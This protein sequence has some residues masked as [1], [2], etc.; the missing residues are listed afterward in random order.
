[1]TGGILNINKPTGMTS[2][3]V[4]SLVRKLT[5]VRRVGHAGTLD[6]I[7]QGVLPICLGQA[8]RVVEYLIGQPKVYYATI[9]LGSATDTYDSEGTV[10]A[11]G[12][13]SDISEAEVRS[14]LESF[15]GEIDQ[16]PPMYSAVKHEGQPLYRY[17]RAG[18]EAPR[19][20]RKAMIY[21]IELRRFAPPLIKA[22][23]ETG[24]GAYVRTIAHDLGERLGCYAHLEGLTRLR[25]GP[26]EIQVAASLD[27]LR[28][29]AEAGTW[30]ELLW[31]PDHVLESW[32]AAI[33]GDERSR[34]LCQGRALLLEPMRERQP[35]PSLASPCRA[36]SAEGEFL[37][38]L[39]YVGGGLWKPEKVFV[40]AAKRP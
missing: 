3:A 21:R 23:M 39:G 19:V 24:R 10:T 5:G 31:A 20:A 7:A 29:A 32:D 37:G 25:S 36:Y 8:T 16:L 40:E 15:A 17:A 2:F 1:M 11:T 9:R 26:F 38:V 30:E 27:Q 12:D 6:P 28:A 33:I 18:K 35:E 13:S 14:A 34:E 4:V 22:E